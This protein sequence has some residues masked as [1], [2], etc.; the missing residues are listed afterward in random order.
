MADHDLT[1]RSRVVGT[2]HVVAAITGG[3]AAGPGY[4]EK[5]LAYEQWKKMRWVAD[6][7]SGSGRSGVVHIGLDGDGLYRWRL[8]GASGKT[9]SG[10]FLIS[11]DDVSDVDD[12]DYERHIA[13][14]YA[15]D[16]AAHRAAEAAQAEAKALEERRRAEMLAKATEAAERQKAEALARIAEADLP[17]LTGSPKQIAWGNDIR[18][19]LFARKADD[20][21]LRS[22]TAAKWWIDHRTEV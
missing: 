8:A 11:G 16:V 22:Q 18:A 5:M 4:V 21:R 12:D 9:H 14:N 19:R 6:H 15:A 13:E 7:R 20:P 2:H 1:G 3:G 17:E 10:Y